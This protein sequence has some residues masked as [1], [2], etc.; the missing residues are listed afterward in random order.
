MNHTVGK[1]LKKSSMSML[2]KKSKNTKI[3][4]RT[5]IITI[6]QLKSCIYVKVVDLFMYLDSASIT[7]HI[8]YTES[9]RYSFRE[10]SRRNV[11][12]VRG[13]TYFCL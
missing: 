7:Y 4:S 12:T 1:M 11:L 8:S 10:R 3:V 9:T 6:K 13:A 5:I 2:L